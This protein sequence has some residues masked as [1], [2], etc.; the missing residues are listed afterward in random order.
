MQGFEDELFCFVFFWRFLLIEL[1]LVVVDAGAVRESDRQ[2]D[3]V[4][5]LMSD[6]GGC[7]VVVE[8]LRIVFYFYF[9]LGSVFAFTLNKLFFELVESERLHEGVELFLLIVSGRP[10]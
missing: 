6:I 2:K 8:A 4:L 3:W 7:E 10:S 9:L 5:D 1:I